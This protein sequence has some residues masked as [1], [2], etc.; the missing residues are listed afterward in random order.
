M[1]EAVPVPPSHV[2][3]PAGVMDAMPGVGGKLE[4]EKLPNRYFYSL[5]KL[6]QLYA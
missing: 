5:Q 3:T 2:I 4:A 1:K 6:Y